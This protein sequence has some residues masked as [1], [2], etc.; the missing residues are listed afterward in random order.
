M[1]DTSPPMSRTDTRAPCRCSPHPLKRLLPHLVILAQPTLPRPR[2]FIATDK[3]Q[4]HRDTEGTRC[5]LIFRRGL[6]PRC[7]RDRWV[8]KLLRTRRSSQ[9]LDPTACAL[10]ERKPRLSRAQASRWGPDTRGRVLMTRRDRRAPG[11]SAGDG[12]V[13]E[14]CLHPLRT[15]TSPGAGDPEITGLPP[16]HSW[17]PRARRYRAF[18][19]L[20]LCALALD[21]PARSL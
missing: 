10:E 7:G 11:A 9:L 19:P 1:W 18:A 15:D 5:T 14:G 17:Q 21:S 8:E 16:D 20:R 6:R 2:R 13:R 4:R 12:F 3:P